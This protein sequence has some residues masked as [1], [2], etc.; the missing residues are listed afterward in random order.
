MKERKKG[1]QIERINLIWN[2]TKFYE[3]NPLEIGIDI[4]LFISFGNETNYLIVTFYNIYCYI[5]QRRMRRKK[6]ERKKVEK[7]T[8]SYSFISDNFLFENYFIFLLLMVEYQEN[9]ITAILYQSLKFILSVCACV[10]DPYSYCYFFFILSLF[11]SLED[12]FLNTRMFFF[13]SFIYFFHFFLVQFL[14]HIYIHL[15]TLYII[16]SSN[17]QK[18]K[19]NKFFSRQILISFSIYFRLK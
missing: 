11:V 17:N 19:K 13:W 18:R 15:Y 16:Y 14:M 7:K 10:C 5:V 2:D 3:W 9:F 4:Y 1:E 8:D 12:V 6:M